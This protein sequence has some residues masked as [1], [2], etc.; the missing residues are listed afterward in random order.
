MKLPTYFIS[1]GGGPWPWLKQEMPYFG[2]LEKFLSGIPQQIEAAPRAVLVISAH[3]E[4]NEFSVM[5]SAK[6]PMVYDYFGFPAHTYQVQ[7]PAPG[8][9]DVA[10]KVQALLQKAGIGVRLDPTRGLDHGTF[11]P[12]VVI[13]PNAGIPV[14][15][16][17]I[18]K[19]L[20]PK[21]HFEVG[22]ALASLREEGVLIIG[23]GLSYHNLR[24][25]RDPQAPVQPSLQF[26]N[27]LQHALVQSSPQE[28]YQQLLSWS[29]A[30]CARDAHPRE[31]HLLPLMVAVGAAEK[32]VATLVHH[33]R[34]MGT[35]T[36]S[37]FRFG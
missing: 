30:P 9:P 28:R 22:R 37:S 25:L 31:D 7:Y 23:S 29:K 3:W 4:T 5:T 2:E 8:S 18:K 6:P 19:D 36:V 20:D 16:L 35:T 32:E 27:W 15:Q 33:E 24:A 21:A 17:S 13:Y 11:V 12:L 34:F 10:L 1:H 26:D 14:L